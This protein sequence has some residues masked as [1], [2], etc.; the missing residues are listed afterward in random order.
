MRLFF[1]SARRRA[2]NVYK[3]GLVV[4]LGHPGGNLLILPHLRRGGCW[5]P[6]HPC[7][8]AVLTQIRAAK[9]DAGA[10]VGGDMHAWVAVSLILYRVVRRKWR[11][12]RARVGR[13]AAFV[14]GDVV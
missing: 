5:V 7:H 9:C 12:L 11:Y 3:L 10:V 1:F 4:A 6:A 13:D 14:L 2:G 8:A